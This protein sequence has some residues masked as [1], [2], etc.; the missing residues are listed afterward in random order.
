[1]PYAGKMNAAPLSNDTS[2]P[3]CAT[4]PASGSSAAIASGYNGGKTNIVVP[5][6]PTYPCPATRLAA[7]LAYS[8]PSHVISLGP[9]QTSH[10][11]RIASAQSAM[12][13]S[14]TNVDTCPTARA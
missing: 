6:K 3:A 12:P 11:R 10:T 7:I 2:T 5:R 8:A 4:S 9:C 14:V 1:M 13:S